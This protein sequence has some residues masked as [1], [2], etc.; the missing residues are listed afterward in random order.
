MSLSTADTQP[1]AEQT[2][3]ATSKA[4]DA[5]R[6][7]GARTH[8]SDFF[9]D[10]VKRMK[11]SPIHS[12]LHLE[13]HI[14]KP[15]SLLAG[16]PNPAM[17]PFAGSMSW[18][19]RDPHNPEK[20][21]TLTMDEDLLKLGLNYSE[22][23]GLLQMR[24]FLEEMQEDEHGRLK[25]E[26]GWRVTVGPGSQDLISKAVTALLNP[27]DSMLVESPTYAGIMPMF[28]QLQ[29]EFICIPSDAHGLLTDKLRE[30]L[31]GWP[32]DK[33]RPKLIYTIPYGS[34][35]S[36]FSATLE[37]RTELLKLAYE[38]NF[39]ILEDD[40]YYNLYYGSSP[41]YPSYFSLEKSLG[42]LDTAPDTPKDL[43]RVNTGGRVIRF[44]SF[45]KVLSAGLRLGF[46]T[47][48][49]P[50]LDAIDKQTS[51][52]SLEPSTLTQ[53]IALT[54]LRSWGREGYKAHTTNVAAFYRSKR[55]TCERLLAQYL[56][57]DGLATWDTPEAGMFM[58][59]KLHLHPGMDV[60]SDTEDF[61]R[62]K[63]VEKGVLALPGSMFLPE[64]GKSA[65]VRLSFSV[66]PENV[67]EEAMRRLRA[68]VI[69]AR[70]EA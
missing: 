53:T 18:T 47:G 39:L 57:K 5:A 31:K 34:N 14:P 56:G 28:R 6:L 11:P 25:E 17:F 16:K 41:R 33:P 40:P 13:H 64:G 22:T 30:V 29:P 37:R 24:Q 66:V 69:E 54:I 27:G 21:E 67:L 42:L 2:I 44:D 51:A 52:A 49:A 58:W 63:A 48:P 70:G 15:I 68:L 62:R 43:L 59:F 65:Y 19:S 26:E 7:P 23:P 60:E 36:G 46:V 10:I 8:Y 38:H 45:S 3:N 12:L 35:P 1:S 50:V 20:I 9:S 32:S 4:N 55:D 61:I